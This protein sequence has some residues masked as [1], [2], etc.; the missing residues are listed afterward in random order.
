MEDVL[1]GLR[2]ERRS[3]RSFSTPL[4]ATSSASDARRPSPQFASFWNH[5][6]M[7]EI[8]Q[9]RGSRFG[10]V[11]IIQPWRVAANGMVHNGLAT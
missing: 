6:G 9:G 2:P 7:P 5:Y 3:R 1:I 4:H 8:F 11:N 10:H